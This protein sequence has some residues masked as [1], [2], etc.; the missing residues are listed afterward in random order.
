MFV[1]EISAWLR[2]L[3]AAAPHPLAEEQQAEL[4]DCPEQ[5]WPQKVAGWN[6][7]PFQQPDLPASR[8]ALP[9]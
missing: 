8:H 3:A 9:I 2:S 1:P 5:H 4:Q 7:G 6:R